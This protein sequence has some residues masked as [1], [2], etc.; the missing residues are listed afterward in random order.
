[1]DIFLF[2]DRCEL[3]NSSEGSIDE[4]PRLLRHRKKDQVRN[5]GNIYG[6]NLY[7]ECFSHSQLY[8]TIERLLTSVWKYDQSLGPIYRKSEKIDAR[9]NTTQHFIPEQR[10]AQRPFKRSHFSLDAIQRDEYTTTHF[11]RSN[12]QILERM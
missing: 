11:G 2:S 12:L 4:G 6:V 3:W 5:Q 8:E 1:M 10:R 9:S 7:W